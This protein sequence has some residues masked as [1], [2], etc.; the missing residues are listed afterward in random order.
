MTNKLRL[1]LMNICN[2]NSGNVT[3]YNTDP[4]TLVNLTS[5]WYRLN[6]CHKGALL[7]ASPSDK[8]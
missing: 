5:S 7:D 6:I 4:T 2:K 3:K 1:G 8:I